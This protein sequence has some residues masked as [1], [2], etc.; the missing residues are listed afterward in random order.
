MGFWGERLF[1]NDRDLDLVCILSEHLGVDDIY[2]PD[3]PEKLRDELDSGKLEAEFVKLRDGA[4]ASDENLEFFGVKTAV[5]VLAASVMR[6]GATISDDFRQHVRK[7]LNSRLQMY[8]QA[9]DDMAAAIDVYRNGTPLDIAGMGLFELANSDER[10]QGGGLNLLSPQM[11][12]VCET[13]EDECNTCGKQNDALL[14]CGRCRKARY[15]N[16]ECQKKA[17]KM[18]KPA[19]APAA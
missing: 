16:A 3:D 13:V 7:C 8:Q 18:H 6:H 15:C 5:V 9:K 10:P 12:N 4:Y 14:H 11:F 19:C 17:W 2:M 1:Q